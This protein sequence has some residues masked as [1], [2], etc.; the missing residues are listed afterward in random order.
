MFGIFKMRKIY[1]YVG[2][3]KWENLQ[4][5]KNERKQ[6]YREVSFSIKEHLE[7]HSNLNLQMGWIPQVYELAVGN[8]DFI[9]PIEMSIK[10]S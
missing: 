3:F 2:F 4:Y 1:P 9:F 8:S 10:S 6:H 5:C 7:C